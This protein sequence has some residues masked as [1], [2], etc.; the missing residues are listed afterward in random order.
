MKKI[1]LTLMLTLAVLTLTGCGLDGLYRKQVTA[2][3]GAMVG[4][5]VT[6][7][8]NTTYVTNVVTL[9][10]TNQVTHEVTQTNVVTVTP[11]MVV[12]PQVTYTYAPASYVTNLVER[13]EIKGL[14]EGGGSMLP[15]PGAGVIALLAGWAYSAYGAMRNKKLATA[16]VTGIEAGRRILQ[17]TPEG[18][19]LDARVKA[20]LMEHQQWAGVL[21]EAGKV[22]ERYTGETTEGK[23]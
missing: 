6:Y 13:P 21:S 11:Q 17:E 1:T 15:I 19:K 9:T 7:G 4:T 20:A 12:T 16:L 22:V 2:V 14:I 23:R 10:L 18:Q 8:T 3:P 5:N